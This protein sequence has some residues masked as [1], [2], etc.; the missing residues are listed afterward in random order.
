MKMPRLLRHSALALV[1]LVLANSSA[2]AQAPRTWVS[3]VGDDVN[4]CSRTAP[5]KTFAGAISKTAPGGEISVLDSGGFGS[6]TITKG[7]TIDGTGVIASV[8]NAGGVN[9][10]T[11]NAGV[12]DVVTLRNITI[13]GVGTGLNGVR[14]LQAGALHLEGVT[15]SG[16]TGIGVEITP[17]AAPVQLT[18]TDTIIRDCV[19]G[20]L[21]VLPLGGT[22]HVTVDNSRFERSFYGIRAEDGAMVTVNR[23]VA[24]NNINSGFRTN[25]AGGAV[26][27]NLE[28]SV[29][30]NNGTNGISSTGAASIIRLSN[31]T[32]TGNATGLSPSAGGQIL[33]YGSNRIS[34]NAVNGVPTGQVTEQ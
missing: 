3:G 33:S 6:V 27:I 2:F 32:I 29:A 15:I 5:C 23:S 28:N 26:E 31:S 25:S 22:L 10:I 8:L 9:G 18:L 13:N 21:H 20:A 12:N 7:I 16:N 14:H 19:G 34:G 4:P 11:V 30:S 24:S 1:A 17:T